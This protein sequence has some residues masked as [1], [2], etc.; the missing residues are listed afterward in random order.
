MPVREVHPYAEVGYEGVG[1]VAPSAGDLSYGV[2]TESNYSENNGGE[3]QGAGV[4]I[5]NTT[6]AIRSLSS[7]RGRVYQHMLE[8]IRSMY[9]QG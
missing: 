7:D 4:G 1:Y 8:R 6:P 2:S 3:L 9:R 5:G